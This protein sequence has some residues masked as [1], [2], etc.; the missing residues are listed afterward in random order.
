MLTFI[1][2]VDEVPPL[3]FDQPLKVEFVAAKRLPSASTC[4][5]TLKLSR[6]TV[7]Y[8]T[9]KEQFKLAILGGHGFGNV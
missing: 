4:T 3:E 7:D 9:F 6:Q 5:L 1:S 8:C 2:A